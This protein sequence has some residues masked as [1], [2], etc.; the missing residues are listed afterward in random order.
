M[1]FPIRCALA[2][3]AL[4]LSGCSTTPTPTGR[5]LQCDDGLKTA[6]KPDRMT[7]VVAVRDIKKGT[8]LTAVDSAQP[9]TAAVDMCLVKLLVGPGSTAET[10]RTARSW[11]EGIGIEVW[12]PAHAAWNERIRNYGGGGWVGGGHRYPDQIGSKV[13]AIVNANMGYASGTHDGGQPHYQ[14]ASFA[15][16]SN[17]RI[18]EESFRDMSSRAIYQQA[19]QTRALVDAYYGK[20]PRYS[21]YDGHSQGGRQGLRVAQERPDLYDGYLIA[22]PAISVSRFGLAALYPQIVMK[23]ELGITV[24]DKPAADAF[25]RKVAAANTRAVA[26]C[27]KEKL[28]FLL[29]PFSCAYDPLRDAGA[30]CSGVAGQGVT[31]S[32]ADATTCMSAREAAALDRIWYGPTRDGSY[33]PAQTTDGRSGRTLGAQQL[34]W[35]PTRGSS[36]TGLISN[37]GGTDT[38]A[39]AMQDV[40]YAATAP[41]AQGVPITNTSTP[42]RDRWRELT[43]ASYADA[44][45]RAGTAPLLREYLTDNADLARFRS[46][47]RKMILWNGLA[48]DVIPAQG[49]VNWYERVKAGVGGEVQVQQFLRLYNIPGMAHSSQGRASTVSGNNGVVPMPWLPGNANQTPTREK[50]PMFS[51]LV[52]WVERG[53]APG[54]IVIASRDNAVSYP[55]C[56]YPKKIS[57]K[58][59]GTAKSAG[60]YTCQ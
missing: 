42:Q 36:L 4:L 3:G 10:E 17:G 11:S 45:T 19:I 14:D 2:I 23:E 38:L 18:N 48:E 47:N 6:F 27:D 30:L 56:V 49:A 5:S 39:L 50:D 20:A 29:D 13:P 59:S 35:A 32:N 41:A 58:G 26:S 12:L 9:I 25:A 40:A 15:F 46:G 37:V 54:E 24:V 60:D 8:P 53:T 55:I 21:Y 44:L 7:T 51:A 31:G 57:W 22:Q 28:G 33:D 52:D 34:W 1:K 43:Y 16:L